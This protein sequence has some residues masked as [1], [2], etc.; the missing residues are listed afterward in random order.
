[1]GELSRIEK[2][3]LGLQVRLAR[4]GVLV[5]IPGKISHGYKELHAQYRLHQGKKGGAR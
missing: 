3:W 1:M 2:A 5:E 4:H